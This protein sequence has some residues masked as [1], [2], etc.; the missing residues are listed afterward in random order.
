VQLQGEHKWDGLWE[1]LTDFAEER[2]LDGIELMVHLPRVGEEFHAT[3]RTK[4]RVEQHEAWRSEIPLVIDGTKAGHI[5]LVGAAG[6]GS[7]C[8]WMGQI[9]SGLRPFEEHLREVIVRILD[10]RIPTPE[11]VRGPAAGLQMPVFA[12]KVRG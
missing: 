9:V 3:W 4:S 2:Q 10:D 8:D 5:K 11:P 12:G 7:F 6:D 1:M